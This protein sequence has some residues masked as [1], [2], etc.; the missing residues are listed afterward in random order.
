M[1]NK[2]NRG[3]RSRKN[4]KETVVRDTDEPSGATA[5]PPA[6]AGASKSSN[7]R[8]VAQ[9]SQFP[10]ASISGDLPSPANATGPITL[11]RLFGTRGANR[12]RQFTLTPFRPGPPREKGLLSTLAWLLS[13]P[14]LG[15]PRLVHGIAKGV[16]DAAS[17]RERSVEEEMRAL[18]M[19]L[20]TGQITETAFQREKALIEAAAK[21]PVAKG[22]K[23]PKRKRPKKD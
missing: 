16:R 20:E 14:V 23:P 3:K 1:N 5:G 18:A 12:S 13:S 2:A 8:P 6:T 22:A 21:E 9:P 4:A 10:A 7:G 19:K 11:A 15:V 17:E